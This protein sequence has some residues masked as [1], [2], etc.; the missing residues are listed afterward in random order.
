MCFMKCVTIRDKDAE[1]ICINIDQICFHKAHLGK[2]GI[3]SMSNGR[4]IFLDRDEYRKFQ[5][6][7]EN[8]STFSI[9]YNSE[10]GT[11][12]G[13]PESEIGVREPIQSS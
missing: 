2:F 4:E 9:R 6:D 3:I 12:T 11:D 13:N 8:D 5:K 10:D 7:I 1:W